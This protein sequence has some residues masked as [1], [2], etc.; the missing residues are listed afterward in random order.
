[1]QDDPRDRQDS[2]GATKAR[3][4]SDV[5]PPPY[6]LQDEKE[7]ISESDEHG[8]RRPPSASTTGVSRARVSPPPATRSLGSNSSRVTAMRAA[9][10]TNS[11][12]SR[13]LVDVHVPQRHATSTRTSQPVSSRRL[14]KSATASTYTAAPAA[15]VDRISETEQSE[16]E[17]VGT[18]YSPPPHTAGGETDIEDDMPVPSVALSVYTQ[19]GQGRTS[20]GHA[21]LAVNTN[22]SVAIPASTLSLSGSTRPR[23]SASM[24]NALSKSCVFL[25][26]C[27]H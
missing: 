20:R 12:S 16:T 26:H 22:A 3:L 19:G 11:A 14:A 21:T 18:R 10:S 2:L 17:S 7:N 23:R 13:P 6:S 4:T 8:F 1:M 15:T 9:H 5:P 25:L 27:F 24:S